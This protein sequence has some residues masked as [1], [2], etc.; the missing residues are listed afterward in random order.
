[1]KTLLP[2]LC[3]LIGLS[4]LIFSCKSGDDRLPEETTSG[5]YRMISESSYGKTNKLEYDSKGRLVKFGK[6]EYQYDA[7]DRLV[8]I[9]IDS[10]TDLNID[11]NPDGSFYKFTQTENA[12]VTSEILLN[13]YM[14][15]GQL[16]I[17]GL[18]FITYLNNAID[19]E[20]EITNTYDNVGHLVQS[21]NNNVKSKTIFR[22]DYTYDT[23]N[24][25]NMATNYS[26]KGQ[27]PEKM[28]DKIEYKFNK[29]KN[30]LSYY[31]DR[32]IIVLMNVVG[33][34]NLIYNVNEITSMKET[35][36]ND[37]GTVSKENT[38][39]YDLEY[40]AAGY[41]VRTAT[42]GS[43]NNSPTFYEYEKY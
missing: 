29:N 14:K 33:L 13:S 8:K 3:L 36:Y 12:K 41:L 5:K 43:G 18:K 35:Y 34:P 11:N 10:K 25:C 2:K 7:S 19:K 20:Y 23:D 6:R 31:P 24:N 15:N 28:T 30:Y 21:I 27:D 32:T 39:N 22:S 1:M 17:Q 37:D 9:I 26:K 38:H 42:T 4:L 40:N 16:I